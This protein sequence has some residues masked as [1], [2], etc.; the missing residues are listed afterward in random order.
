MIGQ[1]FYRF[2]HQEYMLGFYAEHAEITFDTEDFRRLAEKILNTVP[3][4]D[5]YPRTDGYED[6][7]FCTSYSNLIRATSWRLCVSA[8][9]RLR[10][11]THPSRVL[12]LNP[13][14]P[15]RMRR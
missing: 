2:S 4:D 15:I 9:R 6:A 8:R 14:S 10:A 12:I 11:S 7:L 13:Y 5:P 1:A 3:L